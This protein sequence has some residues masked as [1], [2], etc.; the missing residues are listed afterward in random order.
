MIKFN[1]GRRGPGSWGAKKRDRIVLP[2]VLTRKA[3]EVCHSG[4]LGGHMG[5]DRTW[6]RLRN[7]FYWKNM[8]QDVED[9]VK[10]C[11]ACARNKHSTRPNI[12]PFQ[13]TDLPLGTMNHIQF[14]FLG[15]FP[16]AQ[17]HPFRYVLQVQD[18]LSRYLLFFP[19]KDDSASSAAELLMNHW[20]CYF[21]TPDYANSDRG[22]HFTSETFAA[23]CKIMGIKHKLGAPKHPESQG[24]CER[25][26]QLMAQVRC[27]C[28]NNVEKWPEAVYRV[29]FVHNASPCK[30]TAIPPLQLLL[31][32]EPRTPEIAWLRDG[33]CKE[34]EPDLTDD[35]FAE[36][37]LKMKESAIA[38]MITRARQATRDCQV[39]RIEAQETRGEAYVVGDI[40]RIKMDAYEVKKMGK[41]LA[42]RYS[43]KYIVS[44][45][46][47]EGWTYELKPYGWHG[48][49]KTRHFNELKDAGRQTSLRSEESEDEE[50]PRRRR[51]GGVFRPFP[52]E[53]K[54][55]ISGKA[56]PSRSSPDPVLKRAATPDTRRGTTQMPSTRPKRNTRPPSRLQV[57][58]ETNKR[59]TEICESATDVENSCD[60]G[61]EGDGS[62]GPESDGEWFS[63]NSSPG[64][65]H[66]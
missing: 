9:F 2:S 39:Q 10:D 61:S 25:Q 38:D 52:D 12:A 66:A 50:P 27:M 22:T 43:G 30:T 57:G 13:E 60:E 59:Y 54:R 19:S 65:A 3:L 26:N 31:G 48:R 56:T 4:G 18:L 7:A 20:I 8:H 1:G 16:A 35:T 51:L 14:D 37:T 41:K 33:M 45:V 24:Q 23:L 17:S 64:S 46:L 47:G 11:E 36:R 32:Q 40:V 21:G 42:H 44:K 49:K 53:T 62:D 28:L 29:A 15:P 63:G 6:Q 5:R 55:E 58:L 34:G